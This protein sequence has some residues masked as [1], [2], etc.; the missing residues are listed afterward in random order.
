[1]LAPAAR[2]GAN[3]VTANTQWIEMLERFHWRVP[4]IGHVRVRGAG[5]VR[6]RRCAHAA[7]DG[8]VVGEGACKRAV[9]STEG[10]VV[11]GTRTG[12]GNPIGSRFRE[13]SQ[14]HV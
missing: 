4:A 11:H 3:A 5:A 10:Q 2:A 7:G 9:P 1:M 12:G 14:N 13:R 6:Y 8:F